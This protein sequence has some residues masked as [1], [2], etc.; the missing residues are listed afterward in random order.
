MTPDMPMVMTV[1]M[2]TMVAND[3]YGDARA[4]ISY[5]Y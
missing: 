3:V 5:I 2:E 4:I 1:I